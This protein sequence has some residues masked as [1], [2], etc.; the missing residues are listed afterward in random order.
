MNNKIIKILAAKYNLEEEIIEKII[1]SQFNFVASTI[2]EGELQSVHLHYFGKF[3][4]KPNSI[5]RIN[6]LKEHKETQNDGESRE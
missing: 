2:Q 1:R 4:I 3:A 5:A 6:K